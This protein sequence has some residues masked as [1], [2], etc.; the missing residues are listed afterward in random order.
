MNSAAR[1][2]IDILAVKMVYCI[3]HLSS[4]TRSRYTVY[5]DIHTTHISVYWHLQKSNLISISPPH[6]T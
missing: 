1:R 2:H 6:L 5:V 3:P 4:L